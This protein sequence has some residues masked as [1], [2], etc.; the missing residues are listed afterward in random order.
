MSISCLYNLI[1]QKITASNDFQWFFTKAAKLNWKHQWTNCSIMAASNKVKNED[2]LWF[3]MLVFS[4]FF[5]V[6]YNLH[7]FPK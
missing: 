6:Y 2:L 1:D 5:I 3:Q 4:T 7:A